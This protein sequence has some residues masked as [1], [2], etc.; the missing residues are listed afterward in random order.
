MQNRLHHW[1]VAVVLLFFVAL[2][3]RKPFDPQVVVPKP[4]INV[5]VQ[6]QPHDPFAIAIPRNITIGHYF[7]F[8]DSL[9]DLYDSV[10]PYPLS[11][12][13]LVRYNPWIID[14]LAHTDYY[15]R[16]ERD[17]F[18][19]DQ[20]KMIVLRANA[21]LHFPDSATAC[22]LLEAFQH[23]RI[24][25]NIPEYTLRIYEDTL[26]LGVFPV[27]VG[28]N[29]KKYLAMGDRMTDLRTIRG[30]GKIIIHHRN[31]DF[32]NPVDGKQFFATK[33][34]DHRKTL[35]PQIPWMETEING[36]RNGQMIHPTTNPKSL[37]KAYSNGCI[38]IRESDAWIIYYHAPLGTP[39]EIRY[40][41]KV[42][43]SKGEELRL[44]DI[45]ALGG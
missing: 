13:L 20:R 2:V 18:I 21:V 26:L 29:K 36:I 5:N 28:Q 31:P 14:T 41:L 1:G 11:E 45:Y 3:V 33:R 37:G 38:G 34:D 23:T 15:Q 24:D 4:D 7:Q 27:R 17:S 40:H 30:K 12:H 32:Y 42:Q 6:T 44:P 43:G 8:M 16:I 19:Y 10:V 9:V 22:N 39:I 35:M 25:I